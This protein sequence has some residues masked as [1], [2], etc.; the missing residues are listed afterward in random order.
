MAN[1]GLATFRAI[2]HLWNFPANL[3]PSRTSASKNEAARQDH[4]RLL[5][6]VVD[7]TSLMRVAETRA[8]NRALRK[9]TASAY[10]RSKRSVRL[11]SASYP[12][13]RRNCHRSLPPG[14]AVFSSP[15]MSRAFFF[16]EVSA[17]SFRN[18]DV[19][20]S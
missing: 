5:D 7:V 16:F 11:C 15:A 8:V 20:H 17:S 19:G 2:W 12:K 3:L 14:S 9:A 18:C 1:S 4:R 10:A 6:T 13:D